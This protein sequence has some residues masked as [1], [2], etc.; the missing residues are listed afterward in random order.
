MYGGRASNGVLY[1]TTKKGAKNEKIRLHYSA[2]AAISTLRRKAPVLD[3]NSFRDIVKDLYPDQ[4]HLLGA[5]N[6]DWQD[7][8][9]RKA[10]SHDQHLQMSGALLKAVPFSMSVGHLKENGILKGSNQRRNSFSAS[11]NPSLLK[12]HLSLNLYFAQ[13]NQKLR[14]A[15]KE[16]I[17]G[18]WAFDPTQPVHQDN[19]YGGYFIYPKYGV[20][21]PLSMLEQ[22]HDSDETRHLLGQAHLQYKFHFFP[23]LSINARHAFQKQDNEFVT[24]RPAD[25]YAVAHYK[26][27]VQ[28]NTWEHNWHLTELFLN[29][30]HEIKLLQSRLQVTFGSRGRETVQRGHDYAP[31]TEE[32][33]IIMDQARERH[34]QSESASA[35]MF[36][37]ASFTYKDKYTLHA[38]GSRHDF[39]ALNMHTKPLLSGGLGASWDIASET[40]L[41]GNPWLSEL[42]V[43]TN[44]GRHAN[45][46]AMGR[47]HFRD[48]QITAETTT[49]W[50]AGMHGAFWDGK[51]QG[52]IN[53]YT[54]ITDDMVLNA[55]V[56]FA[57]SQFRL[58][59]NLG[60]YKATGV[61]VDLNY[62][63]RESSSFYW[64]VGTHLTT[65]NSE[66][67]ELA[68]G[69]R[70]FQYPDER[71]ALG[72][73]KG[74]QVRAFYLLEQ[75]Y[76]EEGLPIPGKY[77]PNEYGHVL[78]RLSRSSDPA[79][80]VGFSTDVKYKKLGA[81]LLLNGAVGQ[82][83]YNHAGD[84]AS[85]V[86]PNFDKG[87]LVNGT[88]TF[89]E[90]EYRSPLYQ[91]DF[92]L[93]KG[94]FLR[95]QYLNF[96]YDFSSG[97][98]EKVGLRGMATVQ[99]AFVLTKYS[100]QDPEVKDGIDYGQYPQPTT[101]S[102]G[103]SMQL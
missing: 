68:D 19:K 16:A 53:F 61:E 81:S 8:I 4:D 34:Y 71:F 80:L 46:D 63:L 48:R 20:E 72:L 76:D 70:Y 43:Y 95:L 17:T 66:V 15:D 64:Q 1:I 88:R 39:S 49:K 54:S 13:V 78:P 25:M 101:F 38:A 47:K 57:S 83:I 55:L 44:Y 7:V 73:E 85:R 22:R 67:L 102:L 26:G 14:V 12:D 100:G 87:Y 59:L 9:Y 51:L 89:V 96:S 50:N 58:P 37:S 18:A 98:S 90:T 5:S 32:G 23:S 74:S 56:P 41:K 6:T 75:L 36:G 33:K 29:L 99:N 45:P 28:R 94:S 40:F 82:H 21:N 30:E 62:V 93:E 11:L 65:T 69:Y 2:T 84:R 42:R 77:K 92:Y 31:H 86:S 27:W 91:S 10:F 103:I 97:S 35:G 52:N 24:F 79:Y 3:A 60:K